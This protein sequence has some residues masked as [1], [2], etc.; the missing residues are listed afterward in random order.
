MEEYKQP[1]MVSWYNPAQLYATALKAVVSGTFASYADNREVQAALDKSRDFYTLRGPDENPGEYDLREIWFDYISDTGD[2]F[3]PTYT[4]ADLAAQ[5]LDVGNDPNYLKSPN[6]T[7]GKLPAGDMLVLGGDQVYPT[8]TKEEYDSR[9]KVPF[10]AASQKHHKEGLKP[11]MFAIP[12]N[13]DW[14]DGLSNFIKLFCQKRWIGHWR[15]EQR[16]SYFAIKLSH[17]YWIWAVDVQLN[18]DIDQPQKD[19]FCEIGTKMDE[20][21]KVILCTSEP[22]WVYN[23]MRKDDDTYKRLKFFEQLFITDDDYNYRNGKKFEL[24]ATITGDLHHYS[25]YE[26]FKEYR[27]GGNAKQYINHLI[28]A[29]GGGAFLHPTHN[30]PETLTDLD[31]P[32]DPILKDTQPEGKD[33]KRKA[34]FPSID[35]S[36]K[37]SWGVLK[38]P[39]M[40][41]AFVVTMAI[42]QLLLVWMLQS[43][44]KTAN[45]GFMRELAGAANFNMAIGTIIRNLYL[46]PPVLLICS[47]VVG[48]MAYFTD[49]YK[50]KGYR[51]LGAIHGM[52]QLA[53]MF[54]GIWLFSYVNI[55]ICKI[56]NKILY[57][58]MYAGETFVGAIGGSFIFGVYLWI[59]NRIFGLHDNESFSSLGHTGF[60]NFLRLHIDK[61]GNLEIYPI[62]ITKAA[63]DW[64]S[65]GE[66]EKMIFNT[67]KPAKYHLIEQPIIIK[68][69]NRI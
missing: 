57:A 30:L 6:A 54:F 10:R 7:D 49:V 23:K 15:T 4:I 1:K 59:G 35:D 42:I 69:D 14:Y 17:N 21:D 60:K 2:G 39:A 55:N 28:T 40:N 29:G 52:I 11:K 34:V 50:G 16:R 25:R 62:G 26:E 48:G 44:S 66:G 33:P 51:V 53:S 8:P 45:H 18:S 3:D 22:A 47:I 46:N 61:D 20:G 37:L 68:K 41:K 5:N 32:N 27:Y 13:H 38:F 58:L 19:Y 65:S 67:D 36:K 64:K 31:K 9:F 43:T 24:V 63:T 12:G 56:D